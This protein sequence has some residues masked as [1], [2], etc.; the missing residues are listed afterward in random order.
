MKA[1]GATALIFN[2]S[3]KSWPSWPAIQQKSEPLCNEFYNSLFGVEG[4]T[5][6]PMLGPAFF[7]HA[8]LELYATCNPTVYGVDDV[9]PNLVAPLAIR[10]AGG[11]VSSLTIDIEYPLAQR[12]E[13]ERDPA[14]TR[15]RMAQVAYVTTA[16]GKAV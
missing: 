8:G 6:D 1:K 7:N 13:E 2:R 12:E 5:Y 3:A 14:M 15:K 9:Y 10:A 4:E 11:Y 16:W